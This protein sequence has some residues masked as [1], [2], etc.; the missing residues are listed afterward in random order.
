MLK[1]VNHLPRETNEQGFN[2]EK[3]WN[4]ITTTIR[5]QGTFK[6]ITGIAHPRNKFIS[7]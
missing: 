7:S 3:T 6:K 4:T 5:L 1:S 2:S